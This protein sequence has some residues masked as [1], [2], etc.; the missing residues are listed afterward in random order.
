MNRGTYDI[1]SVML[2]RLC[3]RQSEN[4]IDGIDIAENCSVYVMYA[5]LTYMPLV[6][7]LFNKIFSDR[8]I[9]LIIQLLSL[10][11]VFLFRLI[12]IASWKDFHSLHFT[13]RSF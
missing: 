6:V 11:I 1:F 5:E 12:L 2:L 13:C 10:D 7:K 4:C 3:I 8:F 9:A